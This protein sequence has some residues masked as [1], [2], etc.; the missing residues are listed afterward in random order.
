MGGL[1]SLAQ[2]ASCWRKNTDQVQKIHSQR[3]EH[4]ERLKEEW[5]WPPMVLNQSFWRRVKSTFTKTVVRKKLFQSFV[6]MTGM[7]GDLGKSRNFSLVH[8]F[9]F[10]TTRGLRHYTYRAYIRG[11]KKETR[12]SKEAHKAVSTV[13]GESP[14]HPNRN[15]SWHATHRKR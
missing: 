9:H 10:R 12:D 2:F 11:G 8:C 7:S 14:E 5:P 1:I 4:F 6:N 3:W 13:L 15:F